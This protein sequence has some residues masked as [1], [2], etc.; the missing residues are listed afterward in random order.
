MRTI[1]LLLLLLVA[2]PAMAQNKNKKEKEKDKAP[3]FKTFWQN[4]QAQVKAQDKKKL[5][6]LC[7]FE[8]YYIVR[9]KTV[10]VEDEK[11]EI[12]RNKFMKEQF[13]LLFNAATRREIA[14]IKAE[15]VGTD[16]QDKEKRVAVVACTNKAGK[17]ARRRFFFQIENK[18]YQLVMV[19]EEQL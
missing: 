16:M 14:T 19:D 4:F 6:D 1:A 3:D 9:S 10:T 13:E 17:A 2:L 12:T 5:A 11:T 8:L 15:N 18:K 7:E